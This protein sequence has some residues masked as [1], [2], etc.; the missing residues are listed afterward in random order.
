MMQSRRR[1]RVYQIT[2]NVSLTPLIDTALTLLVVFMVAAPVAHHAVHVDL[3]RG[4]STESIAEK[5]DSEIIITIDRDGK[6]YLGKDA[7]KRPEVVDSVRKIVQ[8]KKHAATVYL[9]V[10]RR[11]EAGLAIELLTDLRGV[12]GVDCVAFNIDNQSAPT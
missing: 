10:D 4:E 3:P 8:N 12:E 5:N 1:R 6:I 11:S 9:Q 7:M 2:P